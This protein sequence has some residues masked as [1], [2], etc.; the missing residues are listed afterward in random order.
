MGKRKARIRSNFANGGR[1]SSDIE[2]R[3]V[4]DLNEWGCS[5][6][7][8]KANGGRVAPF[9]V[10]C[11]HNI[12]QQRVD[13]LQGRRLDVALHNCNRQRTIAPGGN[14]VVYNAAARVTARI[15]P[16]VDFVIIDS[17]EL[18]RKALFTDS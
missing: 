16:T 2:E 17:D 8:V 7:G 3:A 14:A 15:A 10:V 11:S 18:F 5:V 4:K 13:V 12:I 6:G 1:W 9:C